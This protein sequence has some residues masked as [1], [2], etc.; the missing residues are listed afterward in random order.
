MEL[1][2]SS[3]QEQQA[4]DGELK[5]MIE[6][7]TNR[8]EP[9]R[10]ILRGQETELMRKIAEVKK[11]ADKLEEKYNTTYEQA[12]SYCEEITSERKVKNL[13]SEITQID[14]RV[15]SEERDRGNAEEI[16]KKY[17]EAMTKYKD[18]CDTLK[19]FKRFNKRL[20]KVLE[21]RA[22]RFVQFQRYI[23]S[24]ARMYFTMLLSQRGYSGKLKI[25]HDEETLSIMVNVEQTKGTAVKD[26]RSL[27]G[28]ERSLSTIC[29]IMALWEAME[30]PF[31]VL[32]E[33]DVF[34]DMVNRRISMEMLL[35]MAKEQNNRNISGGSNVRIYKMRDPERGQSTIPFQPVAGRE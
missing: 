12:K 24:R 14:K 28:G 20:D 9:M 15:H 11:I 6:D 27:S 31:R 13:E 34:M 17:H 8:M 29:F 26:T 7:L 18:I 23:V 33:F 21:R 10:E 5:T 3:V 25:D 30:S 22:K 19:S 16:T 1:R 4:K 2:K 32:D 35:K